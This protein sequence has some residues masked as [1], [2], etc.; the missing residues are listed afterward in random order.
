MTDIK[1]TDLTAMTTPANDDLLVVVDDSETQTK[2]ITW[3]NAKVSL[4]GNVNTSGAPVDDD[5]AKFTDA[6]TVEGRSYGQVRQDLNVED[7]AD[8]TDAT[9]VDAA[10][11]VME[12][13]F[14]A[15]GDILVASADDTPAN[16]GVGTDDQILIADSGETP[17][18]KW[19][20]FPGITSLVLSGD[21]GDD[22]TI[23]D[24]N[25]IE[26]AGGTG[27]DTVAAATDKVTIA[28][29]DEQFT[30]ALKTKLDAIETLADVTDDTNVN[31]A[32]AIMES[33]MDAK[34]DILLGTADNTVDRLAIGS[35]DQ[36]LTADSGETT[37]TKWADVTVTDGVMD[38]DFN[39]KG[40][41][42]SASADDTPLILSVG[43]NA[44]VLSAN[45]TKASGLEWVSAT[46]P[47]VHKDAHDPEDGSDKLDT[48]A[49]SELAS[50]QASGAG[51]SHSLARADHAHQ[52]QHSIANN[53]LV[54]IDGTT[55]QPVTTDYAKF[56]ALGL[57]GM[58]ASQILTD[59]GV[60]S[61]ADVTGN[62]APQAHKDA[63]DPEDGSDK[64]D[65][66]A[67]AEISVVVAASVGVSH[68]LARADH[69]HAINHAITDNHLATYDGTQNSGETVRMTDNGLES[70]TDAE[71]KAQLGIPVDA[72]NVDIDTG[73]ETVD[74]FADTSGEGVFWFYV[75]IDNDDAT[76]RRAG[77]VIA[78]WDA[79]N[80]T[81]EYT[82]SST[83][84]VG[85]TS[86]IV[87]AADIDTNNIRL[88]ATAGSDNWT[89]R[90]KRMVL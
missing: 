81:I 35:D 63:H 22:Q 85:D 84:D 72:S 28:L 41:I 90:C 78:T 17:G 73:T 38:A 70:R 68:S 82:E 25:T 14:D 60:T 77:Q 75:V 23:T 47:G 42:L 19:A 36:V 86:D 65:T 21:T 62:N 32:G 66:A 74:S 55:N 11:A 39:A 31:A 54:T 20:A 34:G 64:L 18:V 69:V 13:D 16:L 58:E 61:G 56:T 10:G 57:E 1:I 15:K 37:G 24:T 30:A 44:Q 53:H 79:T 33:D 8:A 52:I 50:V 2:K 80:D 7:G 49:P 48:A 76:N 12:T 29:A 87:L 6:T 9:N 43:T 45:S 59:I 27:I 83:L 46:T 26:I 67:P 3:S 71:M 89:V 51:S 4:G 5:Y 88:R 40:D